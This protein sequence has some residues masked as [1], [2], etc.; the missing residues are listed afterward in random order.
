VSQQQD[1]CG[2]LFHFEPLELT[3][4][5]RGSPHIFLDIAE[6]PVYEHH[7]AFGM[8][9]EGQPVQ[10]VVDV[11]AEAFGRPGQA[12]PRQS[13][14]AISVQATRSNQVMV[15]RYAD[16][17]VRPQSLD[18]LIGQ[19]PI[20]HEVAQAQVPIDAMLTEHVLTGPRLLVHRV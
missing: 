12:L 7:A 9:A 17:L 6:R 15:S 16:W 2:R 11:V 18:T 20:A 4:S 13:P 1:A 14:A 8:S 5:G 19:R 10:V 3:H